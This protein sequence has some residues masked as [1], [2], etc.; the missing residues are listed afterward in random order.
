MKDKKPKKRKS[1]SKK[2]QTKKKW[3]QGMDLKEGAFTEY[4]KKKGYKKVTK[5]CIEEGKRSKNPKTR[6]RAVLAETFKKIA[7]K[8]KKKK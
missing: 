3:I 5:K 2:K 7:K 4:C 1:A 6:K 8:R